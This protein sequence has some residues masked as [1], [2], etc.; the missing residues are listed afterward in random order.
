MAQYADPFMQNLRSF[1]NQ[2]RASTGKRASI[3]E[4]Y[5]M[6]AGTME[7]AYQAQ[8]ASAQRALQREQF[9]TQAGQQESKLAL[10]RAGQ[11]IQQEQFAKTQALTREQ[12][13]N[14]K[15]LETERNRIAALGQESTERLQEAQRRGIEEEIKIAPWKTAAGIIGGVASLGA[16]T[17]ALSKFFPGALSFLGSLNPFGDVAPAS[18]G[19]GG[20]QGERF[21][22]FE[23]PEIGEPSYALPANY[24][25]PTPGSEIFG[26]EY[27]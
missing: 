17:G 25:M 26:G 6:T 3:N 13:E 27:Q 24:A 11:G 7:P 1:L 19:A 16:Q 4:V 15:A 10:E 18:T 12:L 5:G 9:G 14:Q 21:S 2:S 20:W 23:T 22:G 8:Q